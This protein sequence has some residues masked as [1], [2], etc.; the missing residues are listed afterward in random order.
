MWHF[1]NLKKKGH[2]DSWEKSG[3][4]RESGKSKGLKAGQ[5]V[6]RTGRRPVGLEKN[7]KG[8]EERGEVRDHVGYRALKSR[9]LPAHGAPLW[10]LEKGALF[11]AYLAREAVDCGLQSLQCW[12]ECLT[13][14]NVDLT[15]QWEA[16]VGLWA[17]EWQLTHILK[18]H[19]ATPW[20][21]KSNLKN[22]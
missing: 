9:P 16:I 20:R 11:W 3:W 19:S 18:N 1:R 12:S 8:R 21:Q 4:D 6:L 13:H 15:L 14:R 22:C 2:V 7:E 10:G 17:E 5:Y